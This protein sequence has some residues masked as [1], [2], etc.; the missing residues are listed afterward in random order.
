MRDKR[1]L[2]S[3]RF[4]LLIGSLLGT[5]FV[6]TLPANAG[7]NLET[8]GGD[9]LHWPAFSWGQQVTVVDRTQP[10]PVSTASSNWN[11]AFH[12]GLVHYHWWNCSHGVNCVTVLEIDDVG[13]GFI[14]E[15]AITFNTSTGHITAATIEL[16]NAHVPSGCGGASAA[17]CRRHTACQEIGHAMG[18]DHQGGASCMDDTAAFTKLTPEYSNSGHDDHDALHTAYDHGTSH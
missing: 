6:F 4:V 8:A 12:P 2:G 5:L 7:H 17:D 10:W 3:F 18:L 14:G 9:E 16:N 13:E 1:R 15:A 11:T